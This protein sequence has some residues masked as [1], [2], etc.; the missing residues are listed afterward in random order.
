MSREKRVLQKTCLPYHPHRTSGR[1][2]RR[3][4]P[5]FGREGLRHQC[6]AKRLSLQEAVLCS[7][8]AYRVERLCNRLKSR[9]YRAVVCQAQRAN[10]GSSTYLLTLGVRVLT[11]TECVLRRSL[12]Q[13]QVRPPVYLQ[14]TSKRTD[15]PTAERILKTLTDIS[16]TIIKSMPTA[17]TS[18]PPDALVKITGGHPATA[19]VGCCSIGGL[20]FRQWEIDVRNGENDGTNIL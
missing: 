5:T 15:K 12:E 18:R 9:V 20:K 2:H 19:G 17:R 4:Q 16:L 13:D 1:P 7:R 3:A 14:R 10:G 11:V 8:H 6:W